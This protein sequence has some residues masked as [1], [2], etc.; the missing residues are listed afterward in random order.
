[1]A[2]KTDADTVLASVGWPVA[3]RDIARAI[4]FAESHGV[5]DV[6]SAPNSDGSIDR[7]WFQI[8]SKAH[9]DVS[10]TCAHNAQCNARAALRI[11]GGGH[12]F[13]PWTTYKSGAYKGYLGKNYQL[14]N[15]AG[16]TGPSVDS[17]HG[18]APNPLSGLDG[19]ASALG[20][21]VGFIKGLFEA[22]TWLR[23]GKVLAG[24]ALI[25]L[26]VATLFRKDVSSVAKVAAIA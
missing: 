25:L 17:P 22:S 3:T 14:T 15:K 19:I 5:V 8:N 2:I 16:D 9:P 7:G 4:A 12:N 20:T 6:D 18:D 26:G 23:I 13:T 21:L 24:A 11:S 1:L 10:D